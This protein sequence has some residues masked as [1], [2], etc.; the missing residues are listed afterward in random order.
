MKVSTTDADLGAWT[1]VPNALGEP[2]SQTDPRG[3]TTAYSY[4]ADGNVSSRNGSS[5][6]W[7]SYNFPSQINGTGG[8]SSEFSYGPDRQRFRQVAVQSGATTTTHCVGGLL[9][10]VVNA[11]ITQYR[12]HIE[13]PGGLVAAYVRRSSG[14]LEDTYYFT[15]DHLGSLDSVT[16]AT[17]SVRVPLSYDA[18]GERWKE[19]DWS[20]IVPSA[21]APASPG[22]VSGAW[23]AKPKC[24]PAK[25]IRASW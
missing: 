8:V 20:G 18:F 12:H 23:W 11:T 22:R 13:A 2:S 4:D 19:A 5:T 1:L 21:I 9:E 15:K 6:L 10:K 25:S 24:C 16:N 17:G 7:T 14:V 3:N